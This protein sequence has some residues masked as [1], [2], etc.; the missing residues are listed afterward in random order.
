METRTTALNERCVTGV[1]GLDDILGGGLPRNRFYLIQGDPGV[2]KTT[3]A[4]QFLLQG[5]R[6]N[7]QGLYI[8]LSETREELLAIA[9][10][11]NWT[12]DD[13]AIFELS[14]VEA[15][16]SAEAQTTFFHPAEV[17]LNKT[18]QI[19]LSEVDRV[20][21]VRIVFDSLSELRLLAQNP[22]RFRRQMLSLKQ[23]FAG[24]HATVL[25]LDDR[26]MDKD[27]LQIQSIVHGVLEMERRS[28]LY[29]VPRRRL[30]LV[31]LRG[32]RFREG[33]HDFIIRTGGVEVFPRLIAGEH[34][35]NLELEPISSGLPELDTLLGG[36]VHRGTSNILIGSAGVGKSTVAAQYAF[37]AAKRGENV[38]IY[39]FDENVQTYLAR[40]RGLNI[41]LEKYIE[42]GLITLHQIDPADHSP[43]ELAHMVRQ[44]VDR[45]GARMVVIDSLNGYMNSM[46][47][48]PFLV[49]H[50]HELLTFLRHRGVVSL[51]VMAQHGM[52]GD[53]Q[54]PADITFLADTVVYLR[55][56]ETGGHVRKAI[57]VMKKRSGDH[58]NTIRELTMKNG[59]HV[60]RPLTEFQGVLT[61]VPVFDGLESQIG[62]SNGTR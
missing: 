40:T 51:L 20:R 45:Q 44:A 34:E 48:E 35:D 24:Q 4:L 28:P 5:A 50:L 1:E 3:L 54:A 10:S 23:Y 57:S 16:L 15:Q 33:F 30:N 52:L 32:L 22:L 46:P 36:G 11:H 59:I 58:E 55:F 26:I 8:T 31:K 14:S 56:F 38:A 61:G 9:R 25:L 6:E 41:G 17:E 39:I 12:L 13:I 2:G 29:G 43:G 42:Q 18:T 62:H 47:E 27:G 37:A 7:E 19:L 60:G 49:V 53:V 21:P